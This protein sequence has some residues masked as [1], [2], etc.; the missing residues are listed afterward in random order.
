MNLTLENLLRLGS[1]CQAGDGDD[2]DVIVEEEEGDN[3]KKR[4]QLDLALWCYSI[5]AISISAI[6]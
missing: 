1:V 5:N 3:R 4:A 6:V 2:E